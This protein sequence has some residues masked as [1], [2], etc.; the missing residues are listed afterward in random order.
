MTAIQNPDDTHRHSTANR[1]RTRTSRSWLPWYGKTETMKL[2][3]KYVCTPTTAASRVRRSAPTVCQSPRALRARASGGAPPRLRDIHGCGAMQV[4]F[5]GG[6][7][8]SRGL[9]CPSLVRTGAPATVDSDSA[10][11]LECKFFHMVFISVG[12]Q[13]VAPCFGHRRAG[14]AQDGT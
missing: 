9:S 11:G 1:I 4:R 8:I 7:L 6:V 2:V 12:R 3:V 13:N 14:A 5:N 10:V